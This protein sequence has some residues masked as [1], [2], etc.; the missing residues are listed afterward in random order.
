MFQEFDECDVFDECP[1]CGS[2]DI[3][4]D[5]NGEEFDGAVVK[6]VHQCNDC[7]TRWVERYSCVS[8]YIATGFNPYEVR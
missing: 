4:K 5:I 3:E 6:R 2:L 7:G 1:C 8:F